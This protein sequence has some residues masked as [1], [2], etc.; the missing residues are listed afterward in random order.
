MSHA[1][2]KLDWCLKKA[3]KELA[4]SPK[5]RGLVKI[6]PSADLA[7]EYIKKY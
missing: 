2:N 6:E 3:K 5:H 1:K 7:K 4:D